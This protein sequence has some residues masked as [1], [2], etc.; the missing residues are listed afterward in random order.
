MN[1]PI[2]GKIKYLSEYN[3]CQKYDKENKYRS[4]P[5][6]EACRKDFGKGKKGR[7]I[8]WKWNTIGKIVEVECGMFLGPWLS[9]RALRKEELGVV[10]EQNVLYK[11]TWDQAMLVCKYQEEK[12]NLISK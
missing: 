3:L 11:L 7:K 12:L 9:I 8:L 10:G 5:T 1:L 4:S 2:K 6:V